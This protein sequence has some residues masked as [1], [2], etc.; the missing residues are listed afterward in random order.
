MAGDAGKSLIN[1]AERELDKLKASISKRE[2]HYDSLRRAAHRMM[3]SWEAEMK[4]KREESEAKFTAQWQEKK[5]YDQAQ[6]SA[7]RGMGD[8]GSIGKVFW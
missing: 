7:R 5:A 4:V 2:E 1:A 3:D 6:S 8:M